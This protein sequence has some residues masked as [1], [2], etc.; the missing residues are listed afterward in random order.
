MSFMSSSQSVS[1]SLCL[2]VCRYVCM[3]MCVRHVCVYVNV[4]FVVCSLNI[5]ML[6]NGTAVVYV[7]WAHA[8]WWKCCAGQI[9]A[10]MLNHHEDFEWGTAAQRCV[11]AGRADSCCQTGAKLEDTIGFT[12][13]RSSLSSW[14]Q[15]RHAR[16]KWDEI[17][18]AIK[19]ESPGFPICHKGSS[20]FH[21]YQDGRV[22]FNMLL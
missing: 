7:T 6:K 5:Q 1:L 15:I 2:Y 8:H 21:L 11:E 4:V 12:W 22:T 19:F 10:R 18:T 20:Y 16:H 14:Q 17:F 9:K 13:S 3:Y